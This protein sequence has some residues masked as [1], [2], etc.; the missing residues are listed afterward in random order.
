ML[1]LLYQIFGP[2]FN[3]DTKIIEPQNFPRICLAK[4]KQNCVLAGRTRTGYRIAG[5]LSYN[6]IK[7]TIKRCTLL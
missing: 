3:I 7:A 4:G 6:C 5:T 1:M 2:F